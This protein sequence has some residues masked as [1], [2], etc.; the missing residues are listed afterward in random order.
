MPKNGSQQ[1]QKRPDHVGKE[2]QNKCRHP[3]PSSPREAKKPPQGEDPNQQNFIRSSTAS[4]R[5][6]NLSV[7]T[8]TSKDEDFESLDKAAPLL[9]ILFEAS[10]TIPHPPNAEKKRT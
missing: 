10:A 3:F 5:Y 1:E 6:Q 7:E 9:G 2:W 8:T 4:N